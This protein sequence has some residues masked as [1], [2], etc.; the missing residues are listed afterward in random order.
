MCGTYGFQ[1]I[2]AGNARG[3]RAELED[4]RGVREVQLDV[5]IML[6]CTVGITCAST[7]LGNV[8]LYLSLTSGNIYKLKAQV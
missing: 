3:S 8:V 1:A 2:N 6:C 5:V 7:T 4:I